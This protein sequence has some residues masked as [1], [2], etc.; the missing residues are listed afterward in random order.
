MKALSF[1]G[2][3]FI[4]LIFLFAASL[5]HA[6]I[7]VWTFTPLT[8]TT[9]SVAPND[10]ATIQYRVTN[11]SRKT[12]TLALQPIA[13]IS[14]TT[15]TGNCPNPFTLGYQQS[16]TLTLVVDGQQ[17]Q[18]NLVGGPIVCQQGSTLQCYQPSVAD[19]LD[20]TLTSEVALLT[21]SGSPLGLIADDSTGTMTITNTSSTLTATNIQADFTGTA[22]DGT[23]VQDASDCLSV[24]HGESCVLFFTS[25][26]TAV[27]LVSFPIS[28]NNTNQV[29][30]QIVV[31][32]PLVAARISVAGSPLTLNAFGA[33]GSLTVTNNS[34]IL[35]ATNISA[36]ISGALA[37]AGVTQNATACAS[38]VPRDSCSL[39]FTPGSLAV[40]GT[41]VDIAGDNTSLVTAIIAVN[42]ASQVPISITAG[43]P[44][45]LTPSGASGTMTIHNGSS[46]DTALNI[47]ANFTST[48]LNGR[49]NQSA[50]TC[51]S[52]APGGDC[53]LTFTPGTTNVAQTNFSIQGSNT[54]MATGAISIAPLTIG[55]SFGGGTV[56]CL[57][58][59]GG[60]GNLIMSTTN[61]GPGSPWGAAGT[62]VFLARNDDTGAINTAAIV[63]VLGAG[64]YAAA[65][66][67]A[68]TTSGYTDWFLPAKN[69]LNCLYQNR[70]ALAFHAFTDLWSSTE[71]NANLAWLQVFNGGSQ[72][73][74]NK[75]TL[76][77]VKCVRTIVP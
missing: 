60:V 77:E 10:T 59:T 43:T 70:V 50:S 72:S 27:T 56:A 48:A 8:A 44:L 15:T 26:T 39:V 6:G 71:D 24:A 31:L 76:H 13:G 67:A 45:A 32:S 5:S 12:H 46:T 29:T 64:T 18:D 1:P 42:A 30:G 19:R 75:A 25:S 35:T 7:P 66:C 28:G 33:T 47:T 57:T 4:G 62:P 17:L 34:F 37:T 54:T 2:Q 16:C 21:V 22:L 58:S 74:A 68:S 65:L 49:V 69:Q 55:Q 3:W 11:Q 23:V 38:V 40:T 53:T 73:T 51:N 14:Q 61:F 20:I 52:V 36:D 41:T 63:S 9:T